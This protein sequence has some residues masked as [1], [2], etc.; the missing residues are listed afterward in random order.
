MLPDTSTVR[1]LEFQ[2]KLCNILESRNVYFQP[3]E[4]IKMKYPAI[5][6]HDSGGNARYADDQEYRYRQ[7]YTV[8]LIAKD[9]DW[10]I[11]AGHIL[12]RSFR[13]CSEGTPYSSDNLHHKIYT[14]Y[15]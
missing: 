13:Y 2:E 9:P 11:A 3:P 15:Y 4:T 6:Y 8:T 7:R 5:V 14:I 12:R 10:I 1:R